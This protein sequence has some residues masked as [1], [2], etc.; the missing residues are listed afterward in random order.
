ML[1]F[2]SLVLAAG[3]LFV[4]LAAL[5]TI[6]L[7]RPL[8]PVAWQPALA[9]VVTFAAI[10]SPWTLR[11][12]LVFG[13]FIPI[14]TGF[15]L[16]MHQSNPSL[17]GSFSTGAHTCVE[18]LG[19][20][21]RAENAKDAIQQA[22]ESKEK[23][24]VMY[25]RSYDCIEMEAPPNYSVFNEAQRDEIYMKKSIEFIIANP[26]TFLVLT[27]YRIQMYLVGWKPRH[28]T[29]TLL[30]FLGALMAWRNRGAFILVLLAAAYSFPF[31]LTTSLMYRYR[32][33]ID[34]VLFVLATGVPIVI[35]STI[36]SR[37][38]MRTI[39]MKTPKS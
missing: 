11:N 32:Y 27:R 35:L 36:R 2:S 1:A 10:L 28:T 29:V 31:T 33:P 18:E 22:R 4:P 3:M 8:K 39:P 26:K 38:G 23:R 30:A 9:I 16:A 5:L 34:P 12:Y 19:P 17:A 20:I 24:G 6:L 7:K 25:K 13:E 14:R 15:G 21:W 37:L